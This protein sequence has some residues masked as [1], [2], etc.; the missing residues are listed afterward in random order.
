MT[1]VKVNE[2]EKWALR[3]KLRGMK[4]AGIARAGTVQNGPPAS[5]GEPSVQTPR[6]EGTF[7]L[8]A[9]QIYFASVF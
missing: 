8:A 3:K 1:I 9:L 2:R 4:R 5:P 6:D 7:V